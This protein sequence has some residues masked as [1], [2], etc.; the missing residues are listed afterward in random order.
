MDPAPPPLLILTEG[1][2]PSFTGLA[3]WQVHRG[4]ELP[5]RP[6]DLSD[7]RLACVGVVGDEVSARAALTASTRG[8]ALVVAIALTGAS[9]Q[10]VV[11]DLH[12][13]T[14]PV[15]GVPVPQGPAGPDLEPLQQQ[16][17]EALA[18]GLTVTAAAEVAHVSR[19]TANRALADARERLGVETTV[20]AVHRWVDGRPDR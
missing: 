19:R 14:V 9:R 6:W 17:L 16:L 12:K 4:F 15:D 8:A 10:R 2:L 7:R 11:E 18:S 5:E 20:A 3:G 13:A 1:E